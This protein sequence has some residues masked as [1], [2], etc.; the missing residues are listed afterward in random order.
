MMGHARQWV[1]ET[2]T[3]FLVKALTQPLLPWKWLD[4][5]YAAKELTELC[6]INLNHAVLSITGLNRPRP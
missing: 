1:G 3:V 5:V 4:P 6:G 2:S